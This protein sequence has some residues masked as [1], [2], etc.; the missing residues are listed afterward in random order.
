M[1]A[2]GGIKSCIIFCIV[3]TT[4]E[5]MHITYT[6]MLLADLLTYMCLGNQDK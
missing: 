5:V 3:V 2:S 4:H 1:L 6:V